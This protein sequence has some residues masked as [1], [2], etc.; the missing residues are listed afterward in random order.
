M[1]VMNRRKLIEF[2]S[3]VPGALTR[4]VMVSEFTWHDTFAFMRML[5][6]K[7]GQIVDDKGKF[8][9]RMDKLAEL[10]SG[11][12]ELTE[13]VVIKS[14][15]MSQEEVRKLSF[16]DGLELLD[17]ALEINLS[18]NILDRAKKVGG[19]F[20]AAFGVKLGESKAATPTPTQP[21]S[22]TSSSA[23]DTASTT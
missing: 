18:P 6:E 9:L 10:I 23:R 21:E 14:T 4:R 19:R 13:F 2:P 5:Y 20:S 8:A 15:G 7:S 16:G 12:Q 1:P 11:T 17:A 22:S 3:P